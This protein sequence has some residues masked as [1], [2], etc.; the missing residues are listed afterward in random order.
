M[1]PGEFG[2]RKLSGCVLTGERRGEVGGCQDDRESG[3]HHRRARVRAL[4]QQRLRGRRERIGSFLPVGDV[5]GGA[6][7]P[8]ADADARRAKQVH[9]DRDASRV[10]RR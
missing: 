6:V 3:R 10:P 4:R 2:A 8:V 5:R 9:G 7:G 1:G